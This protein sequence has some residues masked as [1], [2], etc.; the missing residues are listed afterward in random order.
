[1]RNNKSFIM[2]IFLVA[3]MVFVLLP[4]HVLYADK[5]PDTREPV[6]VGVVVQPGVAMPSDSGV[7]YGFDAEY[8]YKIA[9]YANLR[10]MFHPYKSNVEMFNALDTGDIQ[11]ALGISP[12]PERL[13]RFLFAN[14]GFFTSQASVRVRNDDPR[15]SYGNPTEFNDKN[16][17]VLGSS[18]MYDSAR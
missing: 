15:F 13:Q 14:N 16:L 2:R 7:Y 6:R 4:S 10:P 17:G 18:I 11:M 9:Q 8:M 1:M 3:L 12:N 5:A